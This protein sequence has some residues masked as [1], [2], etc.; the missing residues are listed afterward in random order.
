MGSAEQ[1]LKKLHSEL[2]RGMRF[3]KYSNLPDRKFLIRCDA[4]A[5]E[6]SEKL[7]EDSKEPCVLEFSRYD[8]ENRNLITPSLYGGKIQWKLH[9]VS[10]S[11]SRVYDPMLDRPVSVSNYSKMV[12]GEHVPHV[13]YV[14]KEEILEFVDK[15]RSVC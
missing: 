12:F 10:S 1:H 5:A 2:I 8:D 4:I 7:L 6:I 15:H 9:L 3:N 11:D 13:T 14:P